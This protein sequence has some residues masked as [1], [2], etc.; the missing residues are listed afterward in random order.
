[1]VSF[2]GFKL[3]LIVCE[4]GNLRFQVALLFDLSLSF[5]YSLGE[6]EDEPSA[7]Y[8]QCYQDDLQVAERDTPEKRPVI[9]M[10]GGSR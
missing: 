7:Y 1:M 5:E 9:P 6:I 8:S 2:V 10:R 3:L 4:S